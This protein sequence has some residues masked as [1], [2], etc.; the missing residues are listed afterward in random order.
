MDRRTQRL[1]LVA[2]FLGLCFLLYRSSDGYEAVRLR[3]GGSKANADRLLDVKGLIDGPAN[4]T[5]GVSHQ[6]ATRGDVVS[7]YE[8]R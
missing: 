5:L 3:R 2:L 6:L 1:L 7:R 4:G 8:Q